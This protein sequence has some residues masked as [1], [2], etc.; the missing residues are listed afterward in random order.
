MVQATP[1]LFQNALVLGLGVIGGS[2]A[3]GLKARGIASRVVGYALG[4]DIELASRAGAIDAVVEVAGEITLP[5]NVAKLSLGQALAQAD[6]IVMALPVDVC[7]SLLPVIALHLSSTAVLT[8]VC[9]VK[10][11][12]AEAVE[13]Q[14]G[15]KAHQ[16][17]AAHP[18]A[19]SHFS[20]FEGA[21]ASLFDGA[22][23]VIAPSIGEAHEKVTALWQALGAKVCVMT[24][25]QHDMHYSA[26]SHLPHMVAFALANAVNHLSHQFQSRDQYQEGGQPAI[27]VGKG[28]LDSTRIAASSAELWVGIALANRA[29][30]LKSMDEFI[31]QVSTIRNSLSERDAKALT[32]NFQRASHFRKQFDSKKA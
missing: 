31:A 7:I 1:L 8:D 32:A 28:F 23:T 26:V 11:Q 30:L 2:V 25:E 10:Q 15:Q 12:I 3:L 13:N 5:S 14:L 4:G 24:N 18:I 27:Q 19:G 16:F 21:T 29:E 6:L 22:T 17:V 9:S 20:G